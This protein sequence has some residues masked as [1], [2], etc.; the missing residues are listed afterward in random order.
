MGKKGSTTVQAPDP[1]EIANADAQ[2]NRIDQRTPYGNLTYSG[3]QRNIATLDL[4][5]ELQ[6]TLDQQLQS[7]RQLLDLALGR[8]Q[9]FEANLPDLVQGLDLGNDF[10]RSRYEDSIFNR[11][12]D[13]LNSQFNVQED[14]LRQD[15][16]N[17]GL[18]STSPEI[19]EAANTE[20][21]LFNQGRNEA[22]NN[23]ALDSITRGGAES[24]ADLQSE[25][26]KQLT[27]ANMVESNR[28]RQFNEL[29][30]LLGLNQV[31]QPGLNN[32][33]SPG[34][35]DTGG[36]FALNQQGNMFNAQQNANARN[37]FMGGLF[38][39]G[40]AVLGQNPWGIFS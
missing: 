2:Y 33:F 37:G 29:A 39:L 21:G 40:G 25:I 7:D 28:A 26:G 4:S 19:G 34:Q 23:L 32:F 20:L 24:R 11:G 30:S 5:P 14:R 36:A 18:L 17:R 38:D 3:P 16:A 31:A 1:Y 9:N 10:D 12:A 13:L 15:L 35:V 6:G 22:F 27:N 8:Q